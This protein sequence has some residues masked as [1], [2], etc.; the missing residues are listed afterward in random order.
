MG[1]VSSSTIDDRFTTIT[2]PFAPLANQLFR[3]LFGKGGPAYQAAVVALAPCRISAGGRR[4]LNRFMINILLH[5]MDIYTERR[6]LYLDDEAIKLADDLRD[7]ISALMHIGPSTDAAGIA[8]QVEA[9]KQLVHPMLQ[10]MDARIREAPPS[11]Q[12]CHCIVNRIHAIT[13]REM[14]GP[15]AVSMAFWFANLMLAVSLAM[16]HVQGDEYKACPQ[17]RWHE[18]PGY[19]GRLPLSGVGIVSPGAPHPKRRRLNSAAPQAA[20]AAVASPEP[21]GEETR[22]AEYTMDEVTAAEELTRLLETS[23][24]IR[25][26]DDD[27]LKDN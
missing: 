26:K 3:K 7:Q 1:Q 18:L 10:A 4:L 21:S 8:A 5:A 13:M 20:S 22:S 19:V 23:V 27:R 11:E 14:I 24:N 6:F 17:D 15:H 12:L 16:P 9:V 2:R 25:L